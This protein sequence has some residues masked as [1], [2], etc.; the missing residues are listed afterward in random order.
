MLPHWYGQHPGAI[1][2][3]WGEKNKLQYQ[4]AALYHV[5]LVAL[6]GGH[7]HS[8]AITLW[9]KSVY[10]WGCGEQGQVLL[11]DNVSPREVQKG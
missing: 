11:I 1:E 3:N 6:A 4:V 8:A 9:R 2:L 5:P 7:Y 10:T